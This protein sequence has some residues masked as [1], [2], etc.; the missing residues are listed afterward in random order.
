MSMLLGAAALGWRAVLA[1]SRPAVLHRSAPP[2]MLAASDSDAAK[3]A[4]VLETA[5]SAFLFADTDASGV[6]D[7]EEVSTL[8]QR[9]MIEDS[10]DADDADD[11]SNPS[12]STD[13]MEE[14]E[15][16]GQSA[17]LAVAQL[18]SCASSGFAVRLWAA[19]HSQ[20]GTATASG[21]RSSRLQSR[22]SHR[23]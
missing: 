4:L 8:L 11:E 16:H 10:T 13:L 22:R 12:G 19:R 18:G 20:E 21:A 14:V 5:R 6:L 15:Q 3:R 7:R 9:M 2:L 1:P 23:L 17:R